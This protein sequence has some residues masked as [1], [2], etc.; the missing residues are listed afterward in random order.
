DVLMTF[1]ALHDLR[2]ALPRARVRLAVGRW[3]EDVARR[4]P[5]D[6]VLVW[7]APWVGRPHEGAVG[8]RALLFAARALRQAPPDVALDL[9][10]DLRA[11]LLMSLSGA[12]ARVGYA[13]TGGAHLLTHVLPLDET[14]SW[15]E[16]NRRA[17]AVA[18][19]GARVAP[20]PPLLGPEARQAGRA[21]LA[22]HGLTA[23]GPLVGIHPSGGRP[24]KQWP[25]ARWGAVA[26]RLAA[27]QGASIVVTGGAAD[28]PLAE[29]L[30]RAVP[31]GITDLTGRLT[32]G[33]TMSVIAALDLFLSPDTGP[34]HVAAAVGTPSVSVFGPSDAT[35][36]F[37]GGTGQ[38]GTRNVVVRRDL[39]CAPCN[40]IRRPPE[41][42]GHDEGPECLRL[43]TVDEVVAA[44]TR[45]LRET[46]ARRAPS[47]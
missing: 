20:V 38:P 23:R 29:E 47:A 21:L 31:G 45:L 25:V 44:A 41:E 7:S 22:P 13:N 39:W 5:V 27:E 24:V 42:C 40:L 30:A 14:V 33:E 36:Y 15:V 10:G 2:A 43:V 8:L 6:E 28:R 16:Q 9:Q 4:A 26:G 46:A 32:L 3:S 17:V 35:R 11:A 37:S 1:P 12:R 34:M 19:G 18:T